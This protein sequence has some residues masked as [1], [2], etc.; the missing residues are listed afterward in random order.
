[1]AW[2]WNNGLTL[3]VNKTKE[4]KERVL[5]K[6]SRYFHLGEIGGELQIP[7]NLPGQEIEL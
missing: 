2:C 4:I 3:N 7:G 5:G 1:M 6:A